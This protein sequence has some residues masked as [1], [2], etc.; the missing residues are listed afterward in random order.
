METSPSSQKNDPTESLNES[1]KN[2]FQSPTQG[3]EKAFSLI[4]DQLKQQQSEYNDLRLSHDQLNVRYKTLAQ[5]LEEQSK[6][7]HETFT[8]V[9]SELKT[10]RYTV[11]TLKIEK[12]D[13]VKDTDKVKKQH[14]NIHNQLCIID[15]KVNVSLGCLV[16]II[17]NVD[18]NTSINL[19][20]ILIISIIR[21]WLIIWNCKPQQ[22][23]I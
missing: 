18:I 7:N 17:S 3:I 21:Q 2:L 22:N 12:D 6:P 13:L 19:N 9:T 23:L 14:L 1:L 8:Q 15:E 5:T 16:K 20:R 10:L 4:L 11:E